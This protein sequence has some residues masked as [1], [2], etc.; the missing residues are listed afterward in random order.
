MDLYWCSES[1]F[2]KSPRVDVRVCLAT[3]SF[4]WKTE[5]VFRDR[6]VT[7]LVY[8]LIYNSLKCILT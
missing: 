6:T 3:H 2:W 1:V 5:L 4:F 8:S 7:S